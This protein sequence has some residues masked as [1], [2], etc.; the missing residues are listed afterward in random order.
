VQ[1]AA[2]AI[3]VGCDPLRFMASTDPVERALLSLAIDRALELRRKEREEL[4]ALL[5]RAMMGSGG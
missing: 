5:A 4:A 2:Y 3:L 1:Q